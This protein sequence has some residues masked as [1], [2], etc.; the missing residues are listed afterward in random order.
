MDPFV[1]WIHTDLD[2]IATD[3]FTDNKFNTELLEDLT[4]WQE[5]FCEPSISE[6]WTINIDE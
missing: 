2:Q 1:T 4:K 5:N 6:I 3:L